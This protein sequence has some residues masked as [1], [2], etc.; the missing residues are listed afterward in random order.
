MF[1]PSLDIITIQVDGTPQK[2]LRPKP[3]KVGNDLW[4]RRG[5][6]GQLTGRKMVQAIRVRVQD[7]GDPIVLVSLD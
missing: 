2:V 4:F 3:V 6:P 7:V 5:D 1:I